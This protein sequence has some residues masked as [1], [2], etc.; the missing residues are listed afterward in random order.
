[1]FIPESA[2]WLVSQGRDDEAMEI[3]EKA[4]RFN[5]KTLPN[6]LD[7][8]ENR[9][10][11]E[12]K[13]TK[14]SLLNLL[15]TQNLRKITIVMWWAWFVTSMVYYGLSLGVTLIGG[16]IF[17]NS[18]LS[19]SIE[20]PCYILVIPIMNKF[21]RRRTTIGSLIAAGISCFVCIGLFNKPGLHTALVVFSMCGKFF[22]AAT[23][24]VIYVYSAELFP[25]VVR[26]VGV[27]SS[28][29]CGRVGGLIQPQFGRLT[30][31]WGPMPFLLYGIAAITASLSTLLLPETLNKTL[32]DTLEDGEAFGRKPSREQTDNVNTNMDVYKTDF[33]NNERL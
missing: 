13:T 19:G 25:T 30:T 29:M 22:I 6:P 28:S 4:A 2:R 10:R 3:L 8:H 23:F 31:Y 26:Q 24:A 17:L 21:G 5:K 9:Q 16:N 11:V 18:F 7:L 15:K 20:I 32:P 12:D 1:S 33:D 14:P 27:G